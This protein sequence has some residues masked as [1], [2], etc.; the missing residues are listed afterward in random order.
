MTGTGRGTLKLPAVFVEQRKY[1]LYPS[2]NTLE[3]HLRWTAY[4]AAGRKL[5][6]GSAVGW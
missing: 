2:L 1:C 4:D 5:G 3:P 6:S